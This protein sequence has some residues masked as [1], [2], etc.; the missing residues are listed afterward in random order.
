MR[1]ATAFLLACAALI[2]AG[3][4]DEKSGDKQMPK[5][6]P[7]TPP[8]GIGFPEAGASG[9]KPSL[10]TKGELLVDPGGRDGTLV[11]QAVVKLTPV[12]NNGKGE[13]TVRFATG[14]T[15]VR[16]KAEVD[17]LQF[18]TNYALYVHLTGD[19]SSDDGSSSGP[20]FNF[21]GSSLDP[22]DD[23]YGALGEIQADVSG[24]AKGDGKVPGAYLQGPYSLIGRAVVL[25]ATSGDPNKPVY[26]A[27]QRLACGV[28]GVGAEFASQ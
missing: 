20:T 9:P 23:R 6:F 15:G 11:T 28:I 3:C 4:G 24:I 17:G 21:D 10:A 5:P 8:N 2:S 19:C 26:A 16:L 18:L 7:F 12:K 22:P 14:P 1:R 25:H 13:G 27:G